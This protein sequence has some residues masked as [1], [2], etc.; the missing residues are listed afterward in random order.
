MTRMEYIKQ[1]AKIE[2]AK[3]K[4]F[5]FCH[6][7]AQDFYKK[8]RQF[9]VDM[10]N[11]MQD[12]YESD[13]DVLIISVRPRHGKSR[14]AGKFAQ[15]VFGQNQNEKMMTGSYNETLSTS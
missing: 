4:F 9:L 12:F 6:V 2:L 1:Q 3:R 14:S 15:G 8:E 7:L 10:C 5:Y 13:D 11:E